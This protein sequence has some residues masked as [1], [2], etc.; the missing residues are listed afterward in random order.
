M[1][2]LI[3]EENLN[4]QDLQQI[5]YMPLYL[6]EGNTQYSLACMRIVI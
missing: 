2:K 5:K 4:V 3:V 6:L 1:V